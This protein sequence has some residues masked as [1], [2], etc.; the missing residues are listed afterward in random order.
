VTGQISALGQDE[1]GT[2]SQREQRED[3]ALLNRKAGLC[4]ST[5]IWALFML[6]ERN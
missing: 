4:P 3:K 2:E 6:T 5:D 1:D